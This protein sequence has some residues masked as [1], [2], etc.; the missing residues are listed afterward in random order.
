MT[1][2][3]SGDD[4]Y[5]STTPGEDVFGLE[6]NDTL[7][8]SPGGNRLFGGEG[9]DTLN[10]GDGNDELYGDDVVTNTTHNTLFGFGGN[11]YI[12]SRSWFDKINAGAGDDTV[13][14]YAQTTGQ[15]VNGGS[16]IDTIIM[17]SLANLTQ[18][19]NCAIGQT[20]SVTVDF[21]QGANYTNFEILTIFGGTGSN[22]FTGGKYN[23][24][25]INTTSE[26]S[27]FAAGFLK[28]EGGDD[29]LEFNALP[30]TGLGTELIDGGSGTDL[31]RWTN[32]FNTGLGAVTI[33]GINGEMKSEGSTFSTFTRVEN[34][35]ITFFST[36]SLTLTYTG[37]AGIDTLVVN[38]SISATISTRDGNDS[39]QLF[40]GIGDIDGGGGDDAITVGYNNLQSCMLHGGVGSDVIMTGR[41]QSQVFGDGGDDRLSALSSKTS[42]FGGSGND[43]LSNTS[44]SSTLGSG[45]ATLDGGGGRDALSVE[46]SIDGTAFN[47]NFSRNNVVLPDGTIIVNCEAII[48]VASSADDVLRSSIDSV[49]LTANKLL[50]LGGADKL[51]A[52]NAGATLDGGLGTDKLVGGD[53]ADLLIGGNDVDDL[54]G[55]GGVD[56][57]K[58]GFGFDTMAGGVGGDN[59]F[60]QSNSEIGKGAG[61]RD[62]ILDFTQSQAD[63]I[64]LSLFDA[65][66]VL[67]G[68]QDFNFIGDAAFSGA[69][70]ELRFEKFNKAGTAHDVTIISANLDGVAGAEFE[71]ELKG[72]ITLTATDFLF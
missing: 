52:G 9:D 24:T 37:V 34:L 69:A 6:G 67:T 41:G 35:S 70:G 56:Q 57:L 4:P 63:R 55:G 13:D 36:T 54:S 45:P 20:F 50:G 49:G 1:N 8:A 33:D 2:L 61:T 14:S 32:G 47:L 72:L 64:D 48:F 23:D 10:G 40:D 19:I 53:A 31:L 71:I 3:T 15:D 5:V 44:S 27:S 17:R 42:L 43:S 29:Y 38:N 16:G 12:L 59:F 18:N 28:G 58:G 62:V 26:V 51:F 60:F 46:R 25:L 22:T 21:L 7:T 65:N 11:D 68:I 66:S 30:G 39:I